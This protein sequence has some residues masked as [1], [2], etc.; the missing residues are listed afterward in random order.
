MDPGF[1]R[2]DGA[3]GGMA[4]Q[5]SMANPACLTDLFVAAVYSGGMNDFGSDILLDENGQAV[6][7]ANGELVWCDGETAAVQDI[8]L[9]VLTMLGGLFYDRQFGS[10][11]PHYIFDDNTKSNRLSLKA[12]VKRR[13]EMDPRVAVGSVTSAIRSWDEL[14]ITID[15]GWRF[16]GSDD[17]QN[18]V[19]SLKRSAIGAVME[20]VSLE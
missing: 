20:D 19:I 9:R 5:N 16:K 13:I 11:I 14:G 12:E 7:A 2:N 3:W 1:R 15:A 18:I 4:D 17:P 6:V 8:R 10:A